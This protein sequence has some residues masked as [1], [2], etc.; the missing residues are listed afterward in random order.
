MPQKRKVLETINRTDL[1]PFV[2]AFGVDVKDRR[3][4][5]AIVKALLKTD[6]EAYEFMLEELPK[7]ALARSCEKLGLDTNVRT[8]ARLIEQLREDVPVKKAQAPVKK[9]SVGRPAAKPITRI[10]TVQKPVPITKAQ[11]PEVLPAILSVASEVIPVP[12]SFF[13]SI[14]VTDEV[15]VRR[16]VVRRHRHHMVARAT[17][18][19]NR[20]TRKGT[21]TFRKVSRNRG[22]VG[23]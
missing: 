1:L 4:K 16:P 9:Q 15:L 22:R 21:G 5:D 7:V 11:A 23:R 17:A 19:T 20:R 12:A 10:K 6:Q 14:Q 2:D 13:T 3:K 18:V 8:K